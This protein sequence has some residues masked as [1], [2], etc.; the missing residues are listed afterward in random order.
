[1]AHQIKVNTD[2]RKWNVHPFVFQNSIFR[3]EII[4]EQVGKVVTEKNKAYGN[5]FEESQQFLKIL[6]PNDYFF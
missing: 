2:N 4:A 3:F 6:Y 1:M 5:S